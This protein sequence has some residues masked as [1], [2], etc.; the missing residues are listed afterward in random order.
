MAR[1]E[2]LPAHG[3]LASSSTRER[4]TG[5]LPP[6]CTTSRRAPPPH[7]ASRRALLPARGP[8]VAPSYMR[9]AS[10]LL[11]PY[12]AD[13]RVTSQCA[14]GRLLLLGRGFPASSFPRVRLPDD[15]SPR[16]RAPAR[17]SPMR[18]AGKFSPQC[19]AGRRLLSPWAAT[20]GQEGPL[21]DAG[22]GGLEGREKHDE[23]YDAGRCALTVGPTVF[24]PCH[25]QVGP[26][27]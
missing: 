20:V 2:N 26:T 17:S 25:C 27:S 21:T 23:G 1:R 19:M 15:S 11:Y 12:A 5:E 22:S 8:P 24:Y 9:L 16:V 10:E 18:P 4:S 3:W 7:V 13:R 6:K 14:A